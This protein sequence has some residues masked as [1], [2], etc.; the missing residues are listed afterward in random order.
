MKRI[1]CLTLVIC[2]VA[3]ASILAPSNIDPAHKFSWSENL[4]WMNWLDANATNDGVVVGNDFL[5]GMIWFENGGWMNVGHG[6]GPYANTTG[7]DFGVNVLAGGDLDG[8]AWAENLGW[9]NFGWAAGSGNSDRARFD[10]SAQ[11]F[12]GW[13][14][15]LCHPV[16][17]LVE[18]SVR[19]R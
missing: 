19:E 7:A 15:Y 2:S 12:F 3:V 14:K 6:A 1:V 11:R 10:S 16:V 8:F 17:E 4:G 5:S 13:V 18:M 9:A